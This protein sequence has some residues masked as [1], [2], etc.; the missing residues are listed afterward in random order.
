MIRAPCPGWAGRAHV[1]LGLVFRS[2]RPHSRARRQGATCHAVRRLDNDLLPVL[3]AIIGCHTGDGPGAHLSPWP[4]PRCLHLWWVIRW[5]RGSARGVL[6]TTGQIRWVGAIDE[7]RGLCTPSL[8]MPHPSRGISTPSSTRALP[9]H[10]QE[11]PLQPRPR[12]LAYDATSTGKRQ[13]R[14]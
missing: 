4:V 14:Q 6:L 12:R 1:S 8:P 3:A 11:G 10:P 13:C 7:A 2:T 5:A 9:I